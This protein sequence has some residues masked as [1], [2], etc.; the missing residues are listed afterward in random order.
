MLVIV[1][2]NVTHSNRRSVHWVI[3]TSNELTVKKNIQK[4]AIFKPFYILFLYLGN[5]NNISLQ[6]PSVWLFIWIFLVVCQHN[7]S[8]SVKFLEFKR[9]HNSRGGRWQ[10]MTGLVAGVKFHS[11]WASSWQTGPYGSQPG[12]DTSRTPASPTSG[13]LQRSG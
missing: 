13:C 3:R 12:Q 5:K 9:C 4:P 2:F 11:R 8:G 1:N 7:F 6:I 10:P